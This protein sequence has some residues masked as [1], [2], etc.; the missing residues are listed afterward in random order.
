MGVSPIIVQYLIMDA[1]NKLLNNEPKT[2]EEIV[3][4][5][6]ILNF[7][8]KLAKEENSEEFELRSIYAA[9]FLVLYNMSEKDL[10]R[11]KDIPNDYEYQSML[12]RNLQKALKS[13][14]RL[15]QE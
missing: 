6:R 2:N 15:Y 7:Q 8:S 14:K 3:E 11:L 10:D 9:F 1:L 5:C 12:K 4:L 13:M